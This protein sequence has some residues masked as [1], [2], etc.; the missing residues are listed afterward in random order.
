MH[1][2]ALAFA[3]SLVAGALWLRVKVGL[4]K[5]GLLDLVRHISLIQGLQG[6]E[7]KEQG[8]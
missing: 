1:S 6:W 5:P 7:G 8:W 2:L 3:T 4:L